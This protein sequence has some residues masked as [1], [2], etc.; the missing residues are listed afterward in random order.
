ME[1]AW[2]QR[3]EGNKGELPV[4]LCT[5]CHSFFYLIK[6]SGLKALKKNQTLL[7][8]S[9]SSKEMRKLLSLSYFLSPKIREIAKV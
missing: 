6:K 4:S 8:D 9:Q 3:I 7:Q 5:L 1:A 2:A